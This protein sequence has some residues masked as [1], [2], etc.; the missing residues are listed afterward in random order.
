[1]EIACATPKRR[2]A[3]SRP[4]GAEYPFAETMICDNTPTMANRAAAANSGG[5]VACPALMMRNCVPQM[6]AS[7]PT[8][9]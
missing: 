7:I 1:M 5:S 2:R 4:G 6:T 9:D 8:H 3:P